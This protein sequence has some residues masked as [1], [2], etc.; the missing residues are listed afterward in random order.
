MLVDVVDH[1]VSRKVLEAI[2]ESYTGAGAITGIEIHQGW[3]DVVH[4]DIVHGPDQ[5]SGE[6]FGPTQ[7]RNMRAAVSSALEARRHTV[8]TI[9][10]VP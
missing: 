8:R 2:V 10:V 1:D 4:V 3:S 6:T 9:E 7:L 5:R